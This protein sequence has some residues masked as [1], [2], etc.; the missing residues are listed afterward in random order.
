MEFPYKAIAK[1]SAGIVGSLLVGIALFLKE[2]EEGLIQNRLEELWR[3]IEDRATQ[4]VT[5]SVALLQE[6]ARS[7]G[8]VLNRIFGAK[9]LSDKFLVVSFFLSYTSFLASLLLNANGLWIS[10]TPRYLILPSLALYLALGLLPTVF[11]RK[12]SLIVSKCA[13]GFILVGPLWLFVFFRKKPMVGK[14]ELF[15]VVLAITNSAWDTLYVL[16][17]RRTLD[18][19]AKRPN[20]AYG[21]FLLVGS[22]AA[23]AVVP[24]FS[25]TGA[26]LVAPTIGDHPHVASLTALLLLISLQ[27]NVF[28]GLTALLLFVLILLALMHRIIW[29]ILSRPIYALYRHKVISNHKLVF[30]VGSMLLAYSTSALAW[31]E[32]FR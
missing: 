7:V 25:Q 28:G 26:R 20:R 15:F 31:I 19:M 2:D 22:M 16:V 11:N 29:P 21:S 4:G 24:V 18:V 13:L 1:I 17:I 27:C 3:R 8:L 30:T 10:R 12:W 6:S 32:H 14:L 23:L 5:R 9:I